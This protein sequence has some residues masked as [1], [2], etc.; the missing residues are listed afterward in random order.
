MI[1]LIS[2]GTLEYPVQLKSNLGISRKKCLGIDRT[3]VFINTLVNSGA[4]LGIFKY[5]NVDY[6]V[7]RSI[8]SIRTLLSLVEK[9]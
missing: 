9:R 6:K 2:L 4:N 5:G 3:I 8:E 1:K 7:C